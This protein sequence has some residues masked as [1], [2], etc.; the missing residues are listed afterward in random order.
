MKNQFSFLLRFSRRNLILFVFDLLCITL[1]FC[2]YH[3]RSPG[4]N[5]FTWTSSIA[6]NQFFRAEVTSDTLVTIP[7]WRGSSL[8]KT[9]SSIQV[10]YR[11]LKKYRQSS[12]DMLGWVWYYDMSP[13]R[14]ITSASNIFKL[15]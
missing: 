13:H 9:Q 7:I 1:L 2:A 3:F 8:Y 4:Q 6:G 14:D 5:T 11:D 10:P 12:L 15:P